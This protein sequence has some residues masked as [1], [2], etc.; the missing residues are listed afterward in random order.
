MFLTEMSGD[1]R[2]TWQRSSMGK[3]VSRIAAYLRRRRLSPD[4]ALNG[5]RH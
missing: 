2:F 3:R 5:D 1:I 4:D